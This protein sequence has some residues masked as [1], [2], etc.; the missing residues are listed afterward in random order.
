MLRVFEHLLLLLSSAAL[1][2]AALAV[3]SLATPRRLEQV[4]AAA[5]LAAS[6][7]VGEALV[8]GLLGLGG[9]AVALAL[10]AGLTYLIAARVHRAGLTGLAS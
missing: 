8:L 2:A 4:V 5:P 6:A 7:A 1:Y 3:A 10:D 9:S